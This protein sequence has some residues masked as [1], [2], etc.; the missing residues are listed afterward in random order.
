MYPYILK[1]TNGIDDHPLRDW[2][3]DNSHTIQA[4]CKII[5]DSLNKFEK[6]KGFDVLWEKLRKNKA[7]LWEFLVELRTARAIYE[8]SKNKELIFTFNVNISNNNKDIDLLLENNFKVAIEMTS[9]GKCKNINLL[10]NKLFSIANDEGCT[11]EIRYEDNIPELSDY[12]R[13]KDICSKFKSSVST[14]NK[15]TFLDGK[16]SLCKSDRTRSS[17]GTKDSKPPSEEKMLQD[18]QQRI[19]DK[20]ERFI[21]SPYKNILI[22]EMQHYDSISQYYFE[23]FTLNIGGYEDCAKRLLQGIPKEIST[24]FFQWSNIDTIKPHWQ[25]VADPKAIKIIQLP[26]CDLL[27]YLER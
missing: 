6:C 11:I 15:F 16:I 27:E 12:R 20:V 5:N 18:I 21:G 8:S 3:N 10:I 25:F 19:N 22:I 7:K 9:M 4:T 1:L 26:S 23:N 17:A 14:L 2:M 24:V 13:V